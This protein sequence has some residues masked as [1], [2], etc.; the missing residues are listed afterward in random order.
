MAFQAARFISRHRLWRGTGGRERAGSG[1][2][3]KEGDSFLFITRYYS[4]KNT[5]LAKFWNFLLHPPMLKRKFWKQENVNLYTGWKNS[6]YSGE[7]ENPSIRLRHRSWPVINFI[8]TQLSPAE[9]KARKWTRMLSFGTVWKLN[10]GFWSSWL[11]WTLERYY[12]GWESGGKGAQNNGRR[13]NMVREAGD[14][15]PPV[16]PHSSSSGQ[17]S[18]SIQPYLNAKL[19]GQASR[20]SFSRSNTQLRP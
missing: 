19:A 9:L 3:N 15:D 20:I 14:S 11:T 1:S 5:C 13:E 7:F 8:G 4:V 2:R 6:I 18:S 10:P 16:S 17:K 12:E